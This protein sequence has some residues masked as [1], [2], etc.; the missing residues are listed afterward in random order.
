VGP[1]GITVNSVLL[2]GATDT[3]LLCASNTDDGLRMA[4]AMTPLGR[5]GRPDDIADVVAFLVGPDGGWLSS[6]DA[7]VVRRR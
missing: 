3:A 7:K 4:A 6:G 1:R 2:P 5:L